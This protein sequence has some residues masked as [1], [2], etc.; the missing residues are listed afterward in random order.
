[1]RN[2][3]PHT[4]I[5]KLSTLNPK[6]LSL[7]LNVE[8]KLR[9]EVELYQTLE[10]KQ[11]M[12]TAWG[13][14]VVQHSEDVP[15]VKSQTWNL[16]PK[17]ETSDPKHKTRKHKTQNTKFKTQNP[18]DLFLRS[19]PSTQTPD[20]RSLEQCGDAALRRRSTRQISNLR[21]KAQV[22]KAWR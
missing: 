10:R 3:Q 5:P 8:P 4:Q 2:L 6:P 9:T 18:D 22:D 15:G 21:P 20:G 17:P 7:T 12:D 13:N 16:Y 19:R 1:M 14:A 11:Q